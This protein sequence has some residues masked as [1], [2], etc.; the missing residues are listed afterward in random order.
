[1]T[2]LFSKEDRS[3]YATQIE[4]SPF[5]P[6]P[7]NHYKELAEKF[8]KLL[9]SEREAHSASK[10]EITRLKDTVDSLRKHF[11]MQIE[12]PGTP[13]PINLRREVPVRPRRLFEL[14]QLDPEDESWMEFDE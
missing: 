6:T 3:F 4:Q 13:E 8:E 12:E 5:S 9:A 14:N 7:I 2:S 11:G 1:M 10:R